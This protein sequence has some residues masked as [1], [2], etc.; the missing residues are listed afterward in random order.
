[1]ILMDPSSL[2]R[3]VTLVYSTYY[4]P[5]PVEY[6]AMITQLDAHSLGNFPKPALGGF[7]YW[8]S[9]GGGSGGTYLN[10]DHVE[11]EY[12][13]AENYSNT[14]EEI[15]SKPIRYFDFTDNTTYPLR[16]L[17]SSGGYIF[18]IA[19][20]GDGTYRHYESAPTDVGAQMFSNEL[21]TTN[22]TGDAMG[23]GLTNSN[24]IVGRAG[25]TTSAAQDCLNYT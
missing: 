24:Y 3:R 19:D 10:W 4:L 15:A 22:P 7:V 2:K 25:H 17:M 21:F 14:E 16:T 12:T 6:T 23:A 8:T 18:H 13:Y 9:K 20:N 5:C 1:M 11:E